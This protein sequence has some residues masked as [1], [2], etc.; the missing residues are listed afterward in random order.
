MADESPPYAPEGTP[1]ELGL[2]GWAKV[3]CSAVFVSGRDPDEAFANSGFFFMEP[4]DRPHVR[5]PRVDRDDR[6][7]TLTWADSLSRAARFQ[8]DQGCVIETEQGIAF[9]PVAVV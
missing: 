2:A 9:T 6:T 5:A 4:S 1:P 8:G 7:V 3:L